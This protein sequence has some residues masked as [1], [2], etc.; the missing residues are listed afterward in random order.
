MDLTE[1]ASAGLSCDASPIDTGPIQSMYLITEVETNI[2]LLLW[3]MFFSVVYQ[4]GI[5]ITV[6]HI[7]G[8]RC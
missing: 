6:A 8:Q 7:Q 5:D 1:S 4:V 3:T 2:K